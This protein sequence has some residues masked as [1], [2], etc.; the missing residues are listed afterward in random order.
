MKKDPASYHEPGSEFR[1]SFFHNVQMISIRLIELVWTPSGKAFLPDFL[2]KSHR[3]AHGKIKQ[4]KPI[5][6]KDKY[7]PDWEI[8]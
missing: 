1:S 2:V 5:D 8:V 3:K 4:Y 6:P 7:T